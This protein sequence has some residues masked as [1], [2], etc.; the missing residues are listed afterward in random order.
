MMF[1]TMGS[2][3][4]IRCS[5]MALKVVVND[6]LASV[7][8]SELNSDSFQVILIT[9]NAN[10][11][12]SHCFFSVKSYIMQ[13]NTSHYDFGYYRKQIQFQNGHDRPT[14]YINLS[15][16]LEVVKVC[17]SLLQNIKLQFDRLHF[18]LIL[19]IIDKGQLCQNV[20]FRNHT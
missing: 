17:F 4:K 20:S 8:I 18:L 7:I 6:E 10:I 19:N 2:N 13:Y 15:V 5:F 11:N 12:I 14:L 1:H 3:Q 16:K 9:S